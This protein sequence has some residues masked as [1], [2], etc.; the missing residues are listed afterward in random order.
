MQHAADE[1]GRPV[2]VRC[3]ADGVLR[4]KVENPAAPPIVAIPDAIHAYA[5]HD[6]H[7]GAHWVCANVSDEL[8]QLVPQECCM[9]TLEAL[10]L[11]QEDVVLKLYSAQVRFNKHKSLKRRR[12][13]AL[14]G[15]D[16][17]AASARAVEEAFNEV[18]GDAS[19]SVWSTILR[20][21]ERIQLQFGAGVHWQHGCAARCSAKNKDDPELG[22]IF[23]SATATFVKT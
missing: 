6:P 23:L 17:D 10:N 16:P 21:G 18:L 19:K 12:G 14:A 1:S 11:L 22:A 8:T 3:D 4:V 13:I 20:P 15:D 5:S 9:H 7:G 2:P